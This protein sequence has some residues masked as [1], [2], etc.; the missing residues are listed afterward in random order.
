MYA[1]AHA[2]GIREHRHLLSVETS[3]PAFPHDWI[4][5]NSFFNFK[6]Q[7]SNHKTEK[8]HKKPPAKRP[9]YEALGFKNPFLPHYS[10]LLN[11][12]EIEEKTEQ[13]IEREVVQG[14]FEEKKGEEKKGEEKEKPFWYEPPK[15]EQAGFFVVK[16]KKL[17]ELKQSLHEWK[18]SGRETQFQFSVGNDPKAFLQIHI[19][20]ESGTLEEDGELYEP[21]LEDFERWKSGDFVLVQ[22]SRL[23]KY[24]DNLRR[25]IGFSS[26]GGYSFRTG[27]ASAMGHLVLCEFIQ[28]VNSFRVSEKYSFLSFLHSLSHFSLFFL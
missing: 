6:E 5:T 24:S 26:S 27:K 13:G 25:V 21:T 12:Q 15:R 20:C 18:K 16:G 14:E 10:S 9:N 2:I 7:R 23:K 4:D 1:G 8:L 28:L 19:L 11:E 17:L 22:P 3:K